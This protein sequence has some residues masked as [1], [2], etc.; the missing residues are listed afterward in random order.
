MLSDGDDLSKTRNID[1]E[2]V[3]AIEQKANDFA[4]DVRTAYSLRTETTRYKE[5][6]MWQTMVTEYML[7]TRQDITTLEPTLTRLA[8]RHGGAA[9]GWGCLQVDKK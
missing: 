6:K 3:F 8:E 9:D 4:N 2:F 1:L 5:R 7:P